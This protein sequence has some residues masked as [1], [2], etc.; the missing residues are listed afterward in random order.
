MAEFLQ[1]IAVGLAIG[2][3]Y[4]LTAVGIVLIYK[5]CKI[6]N[7]SQGGFLMLGAFFFWQLTSALGFPIWLSLLVLIVLAFVLGFGFER[8]PLRPMYGQPEMA[9]ITMTIGLYVLLNAIVMIVWGGAQVRYYPPFFLADPLTLGPFFFSQPQIWGFGIALLLFI[10]VSAY[11]Q[12]TRGGLSMRALAEDNQVAQSI[13]IGI[14][15]ITAIT[16]T[17]A[18]GTAMAAGILLG[19]IGGVVPYM[20]ETGLKALAVAML[21]GLE[22]LGGCIIAGII[23]GVCEMLA[24]IYLGR[25]TQEVVAYVILMAVLIFRPYGLF[26]LKEI[27]RI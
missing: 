9:V 15:W 11:F 5:T 19:A 23:I 20:C 12:Y 24:T 18:V 22:S 7:F 4:A 3:M 21:G 27:E 17:L 25:G 13:G 26:G 16:W 2:V 1:A 10:M 6:F 8:F 14:N